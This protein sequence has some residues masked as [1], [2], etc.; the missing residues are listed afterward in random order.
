MK[1]DRKQ[2]SAALIE[3]LEREEL[4][5]GQAAAYLNLNPCYISMAKNEKS[6]DAMGKKPWDRLE[7]WFNTRENIKDFVIPEGEEIWKKPERDPST[8]ITEPDVPKAR[9]HKEEPDEHSPANLTPPKF[10]ADR[11]ISHKN[12]TKKEKPG[13]S[14][15]LVINQAEIEALRKDVEALKAL[16]EQ[17]VQEYSRKPVDEQI[18]SIRADLLAAAG[19]AHDAH[20]LASAVNKYTFILEDETIPSVLSRLERL[21]K[22]NKMPAENSASTPK[23]FVI[24]QRNY[25]K[26]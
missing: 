19:K 15:K 1:P 3:H 16:Y 14:V 9:K 22:D 5:S 18:R 6:W 12:P 17:F 25:F 2:I 7:E 23:G 8:R 21:E 24:F 26:S 11:V 4:H 13:K 10:P 20:D